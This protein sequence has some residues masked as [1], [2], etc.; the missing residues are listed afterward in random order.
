MK[1]ILLIFCLLLFGLQGICSQADEKRIIGKQG[2]SRGIMVY[3][4]KHEDS[5]M[6]K[7]AFGEWTKATNG[8][9]TFKFISSPRTAQIIVYFVDIVKNYDESNA[10][11][12]AGSSHVVTG[13][14][15]RTEIQIAARPL[16]NQSKIQTK[17]ERYSTMVHE[18]GHALGLGHS[19]DEG[20]VMYE[21]NDPNRK[22]I[23]TQDDIDLIYQIYKFK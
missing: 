23:I 13:A 11:G 16:F 22:T 4:P 6:M 5:D 1:K 20:S 17:E 14:I 19:K 21:Y 15:R 2:V 18:I 10:V 9:I 7:Q 8:K 3:I 12:L